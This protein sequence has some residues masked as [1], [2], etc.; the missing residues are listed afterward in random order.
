VHELFVRRRGSSLQFYRMSAHT[1]ESK[2]WLAVFFKT[3]ESKS[4]SLWHHSVLTPLTS[5]A[6]MVLFHDAF[7]ALK[8]RSTKTISCSLTEFVLG[9]EKRIFQEYALH[10]RLIGRLANTTPRRIVD[11]G[12]DHVLTLYKDKA[13]NGLRLVATVREGE[14]KRTPVW[15]AFSMRSHFSYIRSSSQR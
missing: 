8:A 3:W 14:L 7:V 6:E 15:T 5:T 10:R 2:L 11:D 9:G 4:G 13:S 1:G 12:F